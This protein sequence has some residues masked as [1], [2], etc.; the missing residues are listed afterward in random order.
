MMN[1]PQTISSNF[2]GDC[3]KLA[4]LF[5]NGIFNVVV[6]SDDISNDVTKIKA[7]DVI[8]EHWRHQIIWE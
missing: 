7:D 3:Q 1:L 8:S 5:L 6:L 4:K 2:P